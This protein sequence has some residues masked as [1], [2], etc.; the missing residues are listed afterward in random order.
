MS[1]RQALRGVAAGT[2]DFYAGMNVKCPEAARFFEYWE[3]KH[4]SAA[5]KRATEN[6][7]YLFPFGEL[8]E[9][10]ASKAGRAKL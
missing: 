10:G 7:R 6:F 9:H 4:W 2:C 8:P 5:R 3:S 1:K